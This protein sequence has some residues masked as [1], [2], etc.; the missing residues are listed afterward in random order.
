[1]AAKPTSAVPSDGAARN[2]QYQENCFDENRG[3]LEK[4]L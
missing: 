1:M 2:V 3:T 4:D